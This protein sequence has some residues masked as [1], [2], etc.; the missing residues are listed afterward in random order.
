MLKYHSVSIPDPPGFK[1]EPG[2]LYNQVMY[3]FCRIIADL[4]GKGDGK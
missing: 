2:E 3:Q 4:Q 1:W